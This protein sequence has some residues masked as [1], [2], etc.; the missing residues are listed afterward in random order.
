MH[1]TEKNT[2]QWELLHFVLKLNLFLHHVR[3]GKESSQTDG[4]KHMDVCCPLLSG[5]EHTASGKENKVKSTVKACPCAHLE[6]I[7]GSQGIVPL[8]YPWH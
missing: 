8:Y 6:G 5:R 3:K 2:D 7:Q 1:H 4:E